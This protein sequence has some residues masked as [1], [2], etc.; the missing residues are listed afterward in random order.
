MQ[1]LALDKPRKIL[2]FGIISLAVIML[3]GLQFYFLQDYLK[4]ERKDFSD[5]AQAFIELIAI[6]HE[7]LEEK[8]KYEM[9]LSEN[10][11]DK[12]YN[13]LKDEAKV[14][15]A[16]QEQIQIRDTTIT[17][18]EHDENYVVISGLATDSLTGLSVEHKVLA[19]KYSKFQELLKTDPFSP[20]LDDD[21]AVMDMHI[22]ETRDLLNKSKYIND[23]IVQAFRE[24]LFMNATDRIDYK[25]L[26]SV[27]DQESKR[28]NIV[29]K[30]EFRVVDENGKVL[31]PHVDLNH[32][33]PSLEGHLYEAQLFPTDIFH[34]QIRLQIFFPEKTRFIW[35]QITW[36]VI[37]T[38]I[39]LIAI[40]SSML[41]L[42]KTLLHQ[43]NYNSMKSDFISNMTH[44]FKTP[45]STISL[46]C[47]A[48]T[49]K[50]LSD[51]ANPDNPFVKMIREENKRLE[52]LVESILQ[53]AVIE[54]GELK[55][56]PQLLN[57]HEILQ[58]VVK[59]VKLRVQ[60]EHGEIHLHPSASQFK[61]EADPMHITNV[62]ANLL[63][64][65]IK[66]CDKAPF[67]EVKTYNES[68]V[69]W[70]CEIKDN[71]ISIFST[72]STTQTFLI[73]SLSFN[74][75]INRYSQM[76]QNSRSHK[77]YLE[78]KY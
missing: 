38:I 37:L 75:I 56:K 70:V 43:Q 42:T 77:C 33:N 4:Q 55:I 11:E 67:I 62:L 30:F 61:V 10:F 40:V 69:W 54:K 74:S 21:L 49:D 71:G 22:E 23:I 31:K 28:S 73:K 36:V 45:I 1:W 19:K 27:I 50:D 14:H 20:K 32:Y 35:K 34:E 41:M 39:I 18:D 3:I 6:Q 51:D 25:L 15:F 60:S 26:E 29:S 52:S 7:K 16:I 57:I 12:Y 78:T 24:D 68:G 9:L 76:E 17:I 48:L 64:N 13:I 63:D 2:L 47:E 5:K 59:N 58:Q 44:E 46:A 65:A 66:Y 8:R 72:N 53:S